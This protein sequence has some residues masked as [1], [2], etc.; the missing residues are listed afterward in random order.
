L[1]F[2]R[3]LLGL[4]IGGE[5]PLAAT[6][7]SE[8]SVDP[9]TRGR[10]ITFVFAAQGW[11][12]LVASVLVLILLAVFPSDGSYL[13]A[14]WRI[15]FAFGAVPCIA[16]IYH[17]YLLFQDHMEEARSNPDANVKKTASKGMLLI[18]SQN[19][20]KLLGTAGSWLIFDIVFYANTLFQATL[21]KSLGYTATDLQESLIEVCK[22][23]CIVAGMSLPG[24]Y[25]AMFLIDRVG[26]RVLQQVGFLLLALTYLIMG[27]TYKQLLESPAAFVILYGLS[28]YFSNLG[29]NTTTYVVPSEV[30][31]EEVRATCHGI[32]AAA[33]KLGGV[34]GAS[35]MPFSLEYF[36]SE[37]T[38]L[39]CFGI[40]VLGLLLSLTDFVP[41]SNGKPLES[42][43]EI[44]M[45]SS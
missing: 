15:A 44:E 20:K 32:S 21:L 17:R 38:F 43:V 13:D 3:F 19:W 39:I 10:N 1:G 28:F 4:G 33:G 27:L 24:Y 29:P 36:G 18:V 6:V 8:S 2:W 5:Y 30:Y 25:S 23:S 26:R 7:S 31:P 35:L 11:G 34:I 16:S 37:G 40:S 41:E 42:R 9:N 22:F 14:I 45:L 12:N